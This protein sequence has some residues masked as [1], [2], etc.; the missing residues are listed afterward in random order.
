MSF[1]DLLAEIS[2]CSYQFS[3]WYTLDSRATILNWLLEPLVFLGAVTSF[4]LCFSPIPNSK[5]GCLCIQSEQTPQCVQAFQAVASFKPE[6]QTEVRW[7][8]MV[9]AN[10]SLPNLEATANGGKN[11]HCRMWEGVR[12]CTCSQGTEVSCSWQKINEGEGKLRYS[13]G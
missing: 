8:S 3:I 4:L 5:P 7:Q 6:L 13:D 9:C 10:Q 2:G 11:S 12:Q 1:C